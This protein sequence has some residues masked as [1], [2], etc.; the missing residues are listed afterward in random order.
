MK[1]AINF[2]NNKIL[3][4]LEHSFITDNDNSELKNYIYIGPY[5]SGPTYHPENVKKMFNIFLEK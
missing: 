1:N 3:P 5:Q 4:I 2:G